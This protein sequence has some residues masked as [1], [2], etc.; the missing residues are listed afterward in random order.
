[1]AVANDPVAPD[2]GMSE[3]SSPQ[4]E[5]MG[6]VQEI[7]NGPPPRLMI[8]KM[9]RV[10]MAL[11]L[12]FLVYLPLSCHFINTHSTL[13]ALFLSLGIG[14]FQE[15]CWS[16]R[17]WALSQVFFFHCGTEWFWKIQRH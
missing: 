16:S 10:Y 4:Q 11:F 3:P 9:V 8:T 1:M 2:S 17:D 12:E 7:E 15:L 6:D 13:H 14:K 5:N